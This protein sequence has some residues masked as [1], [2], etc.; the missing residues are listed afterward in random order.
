[1]T[2]KKTTLPSLRIHDAKVYKLTEIKQ[3]IYARNEIVNGK[4]GIQLGKKNI[5]TK[6]GWGNDVLRTNKEIATIS[7]SNKEGKIH[8]DPKEGKYKKYQH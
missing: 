7:E 6:P 4:I 3:L 8:K 2:E 1:M 5:Y